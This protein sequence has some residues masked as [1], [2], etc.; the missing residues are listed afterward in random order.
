MIVAIPTEG[1]EIFQHFGH[2][3]CFTL[4]EVEDHWVKNTTKIDTSDSGH[5]ALAV[6]LK[7]AGANVLICGGIGPGAVQALGENGIEVI[8][9]VTGKVQDAIAAYLS[10]IIMRAAIVAMAIPVI[11]KKPSA[12]CRL[13]KKP[14]Q[15]KTKGF[16]SAN[17]LFKPRDNRVVF[18]WFLFGFFSTTATLW[19]RCCFPI[20]KQ[21]A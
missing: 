19:H 20:K 2:T 21:M 1:E 4:F 15:Q 6:R 9:G 11:T 8:A 12:Y 13:A 3:Q 18:L 16:P 7:E 14:W 17:R 5:G 10:G